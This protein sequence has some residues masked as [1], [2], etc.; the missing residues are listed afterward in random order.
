[1][2]ETFAPAGV[3]TLATGVAQGVQTTA[4]NLVAALPS[5]I[6]AAILLVVGI[7]FSWFVESM[8]KK[9]LQIVKF[10]ELLEVHRLEESLGKIKLTNVFAAI[11]KYYVIFIVLQLC[12]VWFLG[13]SQV[14]NVLQPLVDYIPKILGAALL[15]VVSGV[16][17]E[18]LRDRI[19]SVGKEQYLTMLANSAKI[20][21]MFIGIVA[22]LDT[23]GFHT[24]IIKEVLVTIIQAASFGVALAIGIAFGLGGQEFA[25]DVIKN[26]RKHVGY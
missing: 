9:I 18:L 8:V 25:K 19:S 16:V 17:G 10:E 20:V 15:V 13:G 5:F 23:L 11:A 1:M 3:D 4:L 2:V 21:V 7:V 6:F 22:A 12:V 24:A 14:A 26:G